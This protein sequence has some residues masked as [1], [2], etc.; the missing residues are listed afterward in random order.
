MF[1]YFLG[2]IGAIIALV[3]WFGFHSLPMLIVGTICYVI[4]T[5]IEWTD[6]NRGAK[7]IDVVVFGIGCIV[8]AFIQSVPF[9][10]VGLIAINIWSIIIS[11]I[12]LPGIIAEIK[13]R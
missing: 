5:I 10:I 11:L 12:T 9:Y 1:S 8:G 2:L 6:L 3:G 4:E 13:Y 7:A